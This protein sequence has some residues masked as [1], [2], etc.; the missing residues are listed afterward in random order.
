M[1]RISTIGGTPN[2]L[3]F[4]LQITNGSF[5]TLKTDDEFFEQNVK[6][7]FQTIRGSRL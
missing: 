2:Y 6:L 7:F 1:N 3:K 4:P 5:S